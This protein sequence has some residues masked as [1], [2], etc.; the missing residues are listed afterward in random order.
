MTADGN[1]HAL[2]EYER[3]VQRFDMIE[4]MFNS[5]MEP[6]IQELEQLVKQ[7]KD[8]VT[9]FEDEYA[10]DFNDDAMSILDEVIR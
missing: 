10:L 2:N 4:S 1:L 3:R 6:I 8:I 5:E 9:H 7:V